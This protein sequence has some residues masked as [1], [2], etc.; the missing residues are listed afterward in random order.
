MANLRVDNL[1]G[2]GFVSANDGTIWSDYVTSTTGSTLTNYPATYG[3]DGN[4][5]NFVYADNNSTMTWTA[6]NG[7]IK[8][9]LIEVYV[10][11]GNTHPLVRVNGKSTGAV[12]GSATPDQRGNWV[13]VTSLVDGYLKTIEADGYAIS[14]TARSSGW[15]AVRINGE[16][17]VDGEQGTTGGRNAITGSVFFPENS[18]LEVT[19][20]SDLALGSG[21]FTIETWVNFTKIDTYQCIIDFRAAGNGAFPFIVRDTD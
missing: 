2:T 19:T 20:T 14:G 21:D 6:P 3:F 13:D 8:A 9:G 7:G 4:L 10:Y 17:L 18:Y 5:S 1:C 16:I 15:S 11:A 12:G